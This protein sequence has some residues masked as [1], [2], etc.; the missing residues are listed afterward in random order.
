MFPMMVMG[1]DTP[2]ECD[3]NYGECGTPEMSGGGNAGGGG[4]IL[5]ANSDLGDTYQSADDYDDDGVE[6][7]YDNCPRKPNSE[8]FDSDGD[9]VGDLCDNCRDTHNLNQ[10]DLDSDGSGDLCDSDMDGD[11]VANTVDNCLRRWNADQSN[12]DG[13]EE[14]DACDRD[15]D[16]DGLDNLTDPC[17]MRVGDPTEDTEWCSPDTD[18]DGIP[19]Y[20]FSSDNCPGVHNP[21]QWDTD[22]DGSGD[23]CDPDLDGDGVGNLQDNCNGVFNFEQIDADRDGRGDEGCD[24]HYCFVVFG[25]EENCLDPEAGFRV[26]SPDIAANTGDTVNLRLF[27]NRQD[28]T[29]EYTWSVRSR[30]GGS[31]A[32]IDNP[33]GSVSE[34]SL[35]DH[36]YEVQP[37]FVPDTPGEYILVIEAVGKF[38][39]GLTV[40]HAT[41]QHEVRISVS[42]A[43]IASTS[44]GCNASGSNRSS[45]AE[46][47]FLFLFLMVIQLRKSDRI[48]SYEV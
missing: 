10:W 39:V 6:D 24:D 35:F 26:Y 41:V 4:S 46:L 29:A 17:P 22:L 1:Q 21:E 7:S 47:V 12:V 9:G 45:G 15:I 43:P 14:G 2:F 40:A 44:T 23:E 36:I 38:T 34:S 3:N 8:Q 30:P 31:R 19:D 28:T 11:G 20:G 32:S 33:I 16:G 25:D 5:I 48:V 37:T 42:G 13:D 27:M 18:G